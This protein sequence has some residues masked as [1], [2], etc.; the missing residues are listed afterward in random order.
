[1][2]TDLFF[3]FGDRIIFRKLTREKGD[4]TIFQI[5]KQ[6]VSTSNENNPNPGMAIYINYFTLSTGVV[7]AGQ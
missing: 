5:I 6:T 3:K 2:G 4:R 7:K 1:M